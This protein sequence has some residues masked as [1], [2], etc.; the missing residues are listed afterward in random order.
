MLNEL[1]IITSLDRFASYR[2]LLMMNFVMV[3]EGHGS[4]Q[5]FLPDPDNTQP[6][7]V[8]QDTSLY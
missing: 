7:S 4:G 5:L 6:L 8:I 2:Q 3:V 1:I